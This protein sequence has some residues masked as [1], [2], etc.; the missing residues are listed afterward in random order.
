MPRNEG[1]QPSGTKGK[2]VRVR[3]FNGH[4]S[5]KYDPPHWPA[6]TLDWTLS[7]PPKPHEIRNFEVVT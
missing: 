6:D 2:N 7:D 3:F 5:T 4:V 1:S